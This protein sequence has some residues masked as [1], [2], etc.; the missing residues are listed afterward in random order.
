[1]T[2]RKLHII[3]YSCHQAHV[4]MAVDEYM[5]SLPGTILRFYGWS[6]P[7]LSFGRFRTN[8]DEID[9]DV[10]QARDISLVRRITGGQT[11]LHQHE[12]TYSI[13][14]A[15]NHFSDSILQTYK[16]ISQPLVEALNRFNIPAVMEKQKRSKSRSSICFQE[17]SSFEIAVGNRK[18]V[19]SAQFRS[20]GRFLQHGSILMD[21][22]WELWK[23][24]WK[25]A[26]DSRILENRITHVSRESDH[27]VGLNQL[28]EM[29]GRKM[30]ET[31]NLK[32]SKYNLTTD[33]WIRINDLAGKYKGTLT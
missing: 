24:V 8:L 23:Q 20:A 22:D 28:A 9:R 16:M 15:I 21:V 4:N 29:I 33:D 32:G 1:M 2:M 30:A 10:C 25:L 6:T 18:L 3:P 7:T 31:L 11:V 14:S 5:L 12:L 13:V 26:P 17:V 27:E 19:G